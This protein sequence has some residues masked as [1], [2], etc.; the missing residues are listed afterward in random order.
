M[1]TKKCS[2]HTRRSDLT[3]DMVPEMLDVM[4]DE[5]N[6]AVEGSRLGLRLDDDDGPV[7]AV[8]WERSTDHRIPP[9]RT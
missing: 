9:L 3:D 1:K 8:Y 4:H 6:S 7:V 5:R 2:T